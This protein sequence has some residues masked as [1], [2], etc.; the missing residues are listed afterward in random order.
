MGRRQN[1]FI[2][3][4]REINDYRNDFLLPICCVADAVPLV[5]CCS[6]VIKDYLMA[7]A[8]RKNTI[9]SRTVLFHKID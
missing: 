3:S 9:K 8:E 7:G 1:C 5:L 2:H 4:E 6:I